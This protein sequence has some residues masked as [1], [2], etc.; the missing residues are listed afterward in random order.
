[1][2]K[3]KD[4]GELDGMPERSELGE[5]AKEY[6]DIKDE[7]DDA[8]DR[9]GKRADDLIPLFKKAK[10]T[11]ITLGARTVKMSHINKDKISVLQ[12]E[13]K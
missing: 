6:L 7:I 11:T 1:M 4:K 13:H 10:T 8:T 2:T 12:R 5:L 9:L 3:K